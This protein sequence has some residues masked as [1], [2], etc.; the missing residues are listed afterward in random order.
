MIRRVRIAAVLAALACVLALPAAAS[1]SPQSTMLAKINAYREQNGLRPLAESGSLMHSASSYSNY[2]MAAGFFGHLSRIRAS[3]RFH[4][5]GEILEIHT[6]E[7]PKIGLTFSDWIHSSEHRAI[8]LDPT[9]TY[10]GAGFTE[11]RWRGHRATIWVMHFG[12]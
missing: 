4:T 8:I 9:F 12:H 7:A 2:L 11:G 3:G 5:L 10:M 6:G 1:A